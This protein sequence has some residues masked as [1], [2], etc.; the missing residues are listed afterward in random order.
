M[1][2]IKQKIRSKQ[3]LPTWIFWFPAQLMRFL[4][5]FYRIRV[6]DPNDYCNTATGMI[7]LMWH[8]RLMF[9]APIFPAIARRRTKAVVSASRDG[10]YVT[11]LISFFGLSSL[12][13]SSSKKGANALRGALEAIREGWNVAFT[14]DGPRGPRYELKPG[15]VIVASM[16][17]AKIIPMSVNAT[18]YWEVRSWDRFQ[19]PKPFSTL[20]LVM[21]DAVS[22]PPDLD[23]EGLER[24]RQRIQELLRSVTVD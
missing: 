15:P 16:T 23:A 1:G 5:L 7:G 17:G 10:Q 12:R 13:G 8:N 9:F 24:E 21:G 2:F 6:I 4:L 18:R 20:E 14:P 3:K 11:D 22:V 19:I